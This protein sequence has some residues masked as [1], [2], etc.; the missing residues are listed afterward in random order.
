[1]LL[2]PGDYVFGGESYSQFINKIEKVA[3]NT[4]SIG[5]P[6]SWSINTQA[7]THNG[8][9]Y[10]YITLKQLIPAFDGVSAVAALP[11]H[12][13][14]YHP[15]KHALEKYMTYRGRKY[16]SL[17]GV[18]YKAYKGSA[19][20]VDKLMTVSATGKAS[21]TFPQETVQVCC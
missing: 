2:K 21:Y 5:C 13:I 18:L 6:P 4:G 16:C 19:V 9:S 1:M 15:N 17:T 11:L 3:Y 14:K 20:A 8:S 7:L 10:G 12:P